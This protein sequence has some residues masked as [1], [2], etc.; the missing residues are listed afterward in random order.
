MRTN[1]Q[2]FVRVECFY[3][4]WK[5]WWNKQVENNCFSK[6][7]KT[8]LKVW[9]CWGNS[10]KKTVL[11]RSFF[12]PIRRI[13]ME[14]RRSRVCNRRRRM[15][16]PQVHFPSD[17]LHTTC[18]GFHT[19]FVGFHTHL[20]CDFAQLQS[21]TLTQKPL[22]FGDLSWRATVRGIVQDHRRISFF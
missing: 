5:P 2:V 18:G 22:F 10:R 17:W 9:N 3:W 13:C 11:G 8:I 12:Y 4:H 15:A 6:G 20:R 19:D 1:A 16:S 7:I 21:C 14:S